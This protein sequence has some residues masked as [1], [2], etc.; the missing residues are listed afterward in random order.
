MPSQ[1]TTSADAVASNATITATDTS[2]GAATALVT[3]SGE[4]L[5]HTDG[6]IVRSFSYPLLKFNG[7]TAAELAVTITWD[8]DGTTKVEDNRGYSYT[9]S[10]PESQDVFSLWYNSTHVDQRVVGPELQYDV[11][12]TVVEGENG[13]VDKYKY[14]IAGTSINGSLISFGVDGGKYD[15]IEHDRFFV[16]QPASVDNIDAL[17]L[18]PALDCTAPANDIQDDN[19]NREGTNVVEDGL[20]LDWKDAIAS[21]HNVYVDSAKSSISIPIG[22]LFVI[23]PTVV[24]SATNSMSPFGNSTFEGETRIVT[25]G[26]RLNVF[27]Y[28]GSNIVY[29]TPNDGGKTWSTPIST[30]SGALASDRYRWSIITT[31]YSNTTYASLLYW[32]PA[33]SNM[34][35]YALRGAANG[36]DISWSSPIL[37]GYTSSNSGTCGSGGAC[38]AVA[39]ATDTNGY[40]YA[41]FGYLSGG[42]T[43]YSY[44]IMRSADG[45]LTWSVSLPQVN[46]ISSNR[47]AMALTMLNSSKMLFAYTTSSSSNIFYRVYGG[48]AWGSEQTLSGTDLTGA[49]FKHLSAATDSSL[50]AYL[51]YTNVT[52]TNGGI[53]KVAR[54]NATGHFELIETADSTLRN[55]LPNIMFR[56][57]GFTDGDLDIYSL[58]DGK[59]MILEREADRTGNNHSILLEQ[60]SPHLTNLRH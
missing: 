17:T 5:V 16:E 41:A 18:D 26:G 27:Y 28:D 25:I 29:R 30:G 2:P 3:I 51:A 38:A 43:T 46:N 31:V 60:R 22:K 9:I 11:Y 33:G 14:T 52:S 40:I 13:Y 54:F 34:N 48:S 6:K 50:S 45:G 1:N 32:T 55:R 47:F 19:L 7:E 8:T 12:W 37:L 39:V 21:G 23:D 56:D 20:E 59:F 4:P 15:K 49:T 36:A 58:A 53:L 57:N 44:Q 42:S 10:I 35:F 24:S